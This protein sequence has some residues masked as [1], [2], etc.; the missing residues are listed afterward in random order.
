MLLNHHD[1]PT[2]PGSGPGAALPAPPQQSSASALYDAWPREA[3]H[4]WDWEDVAFGEQAPPS[5]VERAE[6]KAPEDRRG[7][8]CVAPPCSGEGMTVLAEHWLSL[9]R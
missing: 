8:K 7:T 5:S 4:T 2:R 9:Y 6:K 3:P 1:G